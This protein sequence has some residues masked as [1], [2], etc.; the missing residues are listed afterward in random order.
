MQPVRT[1]PPSRV[2]HFAAVLTANMALLAG[3]SAIPNAPARIGIVFG[4]LLA[5][6]VLT[7]IIDLRVGHPVNVGASA[8]ALSIVTMWEAHRHHAITWLPT[9][10]IGS[11]VLFTG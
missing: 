2:V 8:S 10:V 5:I 1:D 7:I 11:A 3:Y 9:F 6:G 4:G